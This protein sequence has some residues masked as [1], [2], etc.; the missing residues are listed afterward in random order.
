MLILL[1]I[2]QAGWNYN[3]NVIC[4]AISYQRFPLIIPSGSEGAII[5]WTDERAEE[6]VGDV[7]A[8]RI[9]FDGNVL[10]QTNGVVITDA[11]NS[12]ICFSVIPDGSGG[13][14]IIWMDGRNGIDYDIY[15]QRIDSMGNSLWEE[16]GKPICVKED[17]QAFPFMVPDNCKGAITF[18]INIS[19]NWKC[20]INAQRFDSSGNI[21]WNPEGITIRDTIS[22][23]VTFFSIT[24]D[25]SNGAFIVWQDSIYDNWN[26]YAQRVDENGN[27]LWGE[28]IPIC[29]TTGNQKYPIIASDNSGGIY[30]FWEDNRSGTQWDLYGQRVDGNG[31]I[32]WAKNGILID[33]EIVDSW[34]KQ[35]VSDNTGCGIIVWTEF[36]QNDTDIYAQRIDE[37]GNKLWGEYGIPVCDTNYSQYYP[38]A[39]FDGNDVIITWQDELGENIF[40]QKIDLSGNIQWEKNGVLICGASELQVNQSLISDNSGGAIITWEDHRYAWTDKKGD[41]YSQRVF[42]NGQVGLKEIDKPDNIPNIFFDYISIKGCEREKVYVYNII[43]S[44]CGK[45]Y[46]YRVG[47]DLSPGIYFLKVKDKLYK[48]MKIR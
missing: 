9:D 45:Y 31:N 26:I 16:N 8:Q 47:E 29:D 25:N 39:I 5:V 35:V 33:E 15:A 11:E 46:G 3:G 23:G 10:W 18:W 27:L 13:G 21:L 32:L 14:I 22:F 44:L 1:L 12:Q 19:A 30:V 20:G 43:G 4:D 48:V 40:A 37:N 41:I 7:Y 42:D 34:G 17:Y 36:S 38:Q 6:F 2:L 24:S 28:G